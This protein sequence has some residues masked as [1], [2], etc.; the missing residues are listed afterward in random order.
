MSAYLQAAL[1]YVAQGWPVLPCRRHDKGPATHL[2][3]RGHLDAT[4]DPDQV[5]AWWQAQPHLLVGVRCDASGLLVVDVDEP[6]ATADDLALA[7]RLRTTTHTVRTGQGWHFYFQADPAGTYAGR[8][9]PGV[10]VKHHGYVVAPPSRHPL[11][12]RYDL[13]DAQPPA[14][15][16]G[17]LLD[18]LQPA[19]ARQRT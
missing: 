12:P 11:G 5:R 1:G 18:L 7:V 3:R 14:P 15:L 8:L 16:P 10:D 2:V 6:R 17:W 13:V 4:L 19:G 9:G